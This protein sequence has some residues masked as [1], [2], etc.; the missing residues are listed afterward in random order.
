MALSFVSNA[1]RNAYASHTDF[2]F[3]RGVILENPK[4]MPS[5]IDMVFERRG[6][7]LIGEWKREDE[8]ISLGQKILLKALADQDKF[9]VLV[10]NGYSD[11]T[12]TEVDK[13]YKVTED[14]LVILG[15]GIEG[16]KD[17]IDA[18]YQ[19]SNGVSSL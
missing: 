16:L 15:N 7:F 8:E 9:T 3:L 10:I 2:G 4:A 12:G 11:N 13:F 1:M 14:K 19:S 5:N 17:Y 18:W 6:N